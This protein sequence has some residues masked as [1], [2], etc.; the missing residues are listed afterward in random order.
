LRVGR[1]IHHVERYL[2]LPNSTGSAWIATLGVAASIAIAYF[3]AAQLGLALRPRPPQVAVFWPASGV[4]AG[5][6]IVAGHRS[7]L[8][9]VIGVMVGGMTAVANQRGL[10]ALVLGI[11][12][13]GE[14]VLLS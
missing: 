8:A 6:L 4:A 14:A 13:S 2:V 9:V 12:N 3:L 10:L 1:A 7:G 5:I 11:C